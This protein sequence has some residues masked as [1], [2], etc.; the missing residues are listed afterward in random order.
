MHIGMI[1]PEAIGHLN[2][3]TTLG[4]EL[5]G[6][7]ER[8]TVIGGELSRVYAE[9][10]SL[11]Y[12]S[13][14]QASGLAAEIASGWLAVG[15]LGGIGSI[16]ETGKVL[17]LS[18]RM[19]FD[20]LPGVL[21]ECPFDCLVID[22]LSPAAVVVAE[23]RRVP[24]VIACNALAM[25]YDPHLPP[26]NFA[27]RYRPD[28]VGRWRN[29][30]A[31]SLFLPV[32]ESLT[33]ADKAGVR[34]L[35]L[36]FEM[37]HG[38]AI[39]SQQPAWFDFPNPSLP[40]HFHYTGPWNEAARDDDDDFP[41]DKL[42]GGTLVYASMGTLQ[43]NRRAVF[44]TICEAVRGLPIQVVLSRGGGTG[45]FVLDVPEN[46]VYVSTAPQLRLLDRAAA[47][48]THAGLNTALEC[49]ERG[50]PMVCLPVTNDQPGVAMRVECLGVGEVMPAG[51]AAPKKLRRRL[52]RVL[53]EPGYRAR[54]LELRERLSDLSGVETAADIVERAF[55]GGQRIERST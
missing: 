53:D 11:G 34:P 18:A 3:L 49:L 23:R 5:A 28:A 21:E 38:L 50:V 30:I 20:D 39:V 47:A 40:S 1:C 9:R 14:G 32:Y 46:V 13:L 29:R 43:N 31:K 36:A 45:D 51:S 15:R 19:I 8:V 27:W 33:G 26:P 4:R 22:Q 12:E 35:M 48:I 42:D 2:P 24:F 44:A 10:R 41:W 52:E 7:G 17:S 6:R 54:A 25:V 37:D 16:R 55:Q